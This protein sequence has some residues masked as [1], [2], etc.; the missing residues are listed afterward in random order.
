M[1]ISPFSVILG[2]LVHSPSYYSAATAQSLH[3]NSVFVP[4]NMTSANTTMAKA[5]L[6]RSSSAKPLLVSRPA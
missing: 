6:A 1:V 4:R 2:R 3:V 5:K